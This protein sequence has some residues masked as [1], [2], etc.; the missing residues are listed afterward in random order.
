MNARIANVNAQNAG[1][2][3]AF[4]FAAFSMFT[5]PIAVFTFR[6]FRIHLH[7]MH[8]S[9]IQ[10][11]IEATGATLVYLPPYAP[12]LN[13]IEQCWSKLKTYSR[14]AKARTRDALDDAISRALATITTDDAAGRFTHSGYAIS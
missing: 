5:I 9:G 6:V 3:G 11:A 7:A 2:R 10:E 8:A 13:P 14:A 12:D 1:W 4:T